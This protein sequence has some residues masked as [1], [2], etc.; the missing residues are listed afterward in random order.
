LIETTVMLRPQANVRKVAMIGFLVGLPGIA[1][2]QL[3][4]RSPFFSPQESAAPKAEVPLEYHGFMHTSD[5]FQFRVHDPARRSGAFVKL[6]VN[7]SDLRLIARSYDP[8]NQT[9]TVEREGRV[10]TL[11]E[12]KAKVR[13]T[14]PLSVPG[15][16]SS[17]PASDM[18]ARV[19]AAVALN[20]TPAQERER[21]DAITAELNRRRALRAQAEVPATPSPPAPSPIQR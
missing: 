12:R 18:P 21:L 11:P 8:E 9:L 15:L 4:R 10:Y 20:P 14:G 13:P 5:G 7:E 17:R 1:L 2:A 19:V 3:P 16:S 6:N